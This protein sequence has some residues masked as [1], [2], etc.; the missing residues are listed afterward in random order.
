MTYFKVIQDKKVVSVGTVFLRWSIKRHK[1]LICGVDD[2]EFVQSYD[3]QHIYHDAWLKLAPNEAGKHEEATVIVIDAQEYEDLLAILTEGE[4][5]DYETPVIPEQ[6]EETQLPV[7]EKPM[8]IAEMR[9]I[10]SRQQE[11]IEMLIQR[12]S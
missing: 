10:I 12:L 3:E 6:Q 7:E 9:E 8:T 2:G 5:I 4:T 11:Q 1:L